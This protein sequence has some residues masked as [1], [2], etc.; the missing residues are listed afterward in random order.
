M[1]LIEEK[2]AHFNEL[3]KTLKKRGI[4]ISVPTLSR[5][6][7]HLVKAGYVT[8]EE[9][10]GLQLITYSVNYDKIGKI[11]GI[12]ER[13]NRIAKSLRSSK[14]EFFSQS[15][16]QQVKIVLNVLVYRKLNEIKARIDYAL[17]PKSFE[18]QFTLIFWTSPFLKVAEALVIEK[19]VEDEAYRKQIL[20]VIDETLKPMI[21]QDD[22][23]G[24]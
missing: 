20:E 5:H 3:H 13:T 10:E 8:R 22:F 9:K 2:Q 17:D 14:R 12:W 16:D 15:E 4:V 19:S 6:L 21:K 24:E 1:I 7:K 23:K 18:K 11:K